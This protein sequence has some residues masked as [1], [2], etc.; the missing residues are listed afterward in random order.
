[1]YTHGLITDPLSPHGGGLPAKT[2]STATTRHVTADCRHLS[3]IH[4]PTQ[5]P[6]RDKSKA[7]G[8]V[9]NLTVRSL[10]FSSISTGPPA[11]L[12]APNNRLQILECQTS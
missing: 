8:G 4:H 9:T 10:N 3:C 6:K 7:P 11:G 1:M 12:L 2:V 5:T